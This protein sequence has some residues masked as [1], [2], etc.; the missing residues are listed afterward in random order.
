MLWKFLGLKGRYKGEP[1]AY[2]SIV[3]PKHS[4]T[5]SINPRMTS[6]KGRV[7]EY[8]TYSALKVKS[9]PANGTCVHGRACTAGACSGQGDVNSIPPIPYFTDT[10]L[11]SGTKSLYKH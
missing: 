1:N 8:I 3:H 4:P 9:L 2:A 10:T 5:P 11:I 7:P 6:G